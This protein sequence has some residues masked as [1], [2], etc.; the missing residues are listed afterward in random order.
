MFPGEGHLLVDCVDAGFALPFYIIDFK[1]YISFTLSMRFCGTSNIWTLRAPTE[2]ISRFILKYCRDCRRNS[3]A[4][5][6]LGLIAPDI[7]Q[8]ISGILFVTLELAPG[9]L[10]CWVE[11]NVTQ[12]TN[13][14]ELLYPSV[15]NISKAQKFVLGVTNSFDTWQY[16]LPE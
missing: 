15:L 2:W 14:W 4:E 10:R 6:G 7:P 12:I 3:I 1:H 9:W 13:T 16:S 8:I 11:I 5:A